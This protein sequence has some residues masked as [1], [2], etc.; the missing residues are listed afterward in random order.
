MHNSNNNTSSLVIQ[1][2]S[3]HY[4]TNED[5]QKILFMNGNNTSLGQIRITHSLT[6][7][8]LNPAADNLIGFYKFD[9]S[10]GTQVLDSSA[11]NTITNSVTSIGI[12]VNFDLENCWQKGIINNCLAF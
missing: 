5:Q 7:D 2:T 9:H 10:S 3:T 8:D 12:L 6:Y 11:E 4:L 1:N